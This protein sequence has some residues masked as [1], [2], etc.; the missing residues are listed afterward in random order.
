MGGEADRPNARVF[1]L[2]H[3]RRRILRISDPG[4]DERIYS[5]WIIQKPDGQ[6]V[7]PEGFKV[8]SG[9]PHVRGDTTRIQVAPDGE[10][11]LTGRD[12]S[13]EFNRINITRFA[14]RQGLQPFGN[15]LFKETH[16]SGP[17]EHGHPGESGFG[18]I[19]HGYVDLE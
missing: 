4:W 11:T 1:R 7:T 18:E 5:P 15:D 17:P 19:A 9:F 10:I 2:R 14:Y 8:L 12:G 3:C 13:T 6:I 16:A